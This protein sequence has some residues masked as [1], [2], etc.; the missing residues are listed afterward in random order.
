MVAPDFTI[1]VSFIWKVHGL[2]SKDQ[3]SVT[4]GI[5]EIFRREYFEG[6]EH[7]KGTK[8]FVHFP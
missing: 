1:G 3:Q 4:K 8:C 2:N 5:I 6:K 7:R